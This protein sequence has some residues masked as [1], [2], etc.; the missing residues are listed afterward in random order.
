MY[1]RTAAA[2][3]PTV[4][5]SAY[6]RTQGEL[7]KRGITV[8]ANTIKNGF[9]PSPNRTKGDWDRFLKRHM[10]TLW[11]CDFST[12]DVW[13]AFGKVT[14]YVLFFI[15]VGTRRVKISGITVQPDGPLVEQ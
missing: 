7:K 12:K 3:F 8:A 5:T 10:D 15:H 11:A 4:D 14:Y 9:L 2:F 6:A 13:T 1:W